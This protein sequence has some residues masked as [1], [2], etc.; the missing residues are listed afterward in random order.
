M[1]RAKSGHDGTYHLSQ[2]KSIKVDVNVADA[3]VICLAQPRQGQPALGMERL[4]LICDLSPNAK[5]CQ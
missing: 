1:L 2:P 3:I 5:L 4:V